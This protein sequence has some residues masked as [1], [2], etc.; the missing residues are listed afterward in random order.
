ML[1]VLLVL[2]VGPPVMVAGPP[3]VL[4]GHPVALDGGPIACPT[5]MNGQTQLSNL[6]HPVVFNWFVEDNNNTFFMYLN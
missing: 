6:C 1:V 5:N 2:L 4:V 3:V